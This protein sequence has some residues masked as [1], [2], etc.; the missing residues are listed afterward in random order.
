[1]EKIEARADFSGPAQQSRADERPE[2]GR[3]HHGHAFRQANQPAAA[4]DVGDSPMIV[5][6]YQLGRKSNLFGEFAHSG[7][8]GK[9]AVRPVFDDAAVDRFSAYNA[10]QAPLTLNDQ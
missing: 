3:H 8:R 9:K 5:R 4:P 6:A 10:A 1:V 2:S 7:L